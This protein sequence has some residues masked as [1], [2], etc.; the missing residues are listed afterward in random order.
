MKT[1]LKCI[2][3]A[4]ALLAFSCTGSEKKQAGKPFEELPAVDT[5]QLWNFIAALPDADF[6]QKLQSPESRKSFRQVYEDLQNGLLGDGEGE[7][8][9]YHDDFYESENDFYWTDYFTLPDD[10][11]WSNE[12]EDT[13][14]PYVSFHAYMN[15]NGTRMYGVL[16]TGAYGLEKDEKNP[17]KYYWYDIASGKITP[18]ELLVDKPVDDDVL[19]EDSLLLYGADNLYYSLKNKQYEPSF[20]DRGFEMFIES[21]GDPGIRYVWDGTQFNKV[22]RKRIVTLFG[23]GF[24]NIRIGENMPFDVPGYKTVKVKDNENEFVYELRK[25]GETEPTLVFHN[26]R[27][28]DVVDIEI[29]TDRYANMYGIYPGMPYN[30]FMDVLNEI[31]SYYEEPPYVSI[32]TD[33]DE[34]FA[35]I[36]CGFD[37]DF[38]YL[39]DK[40]F[41]KG[42]KIAPNAKIARV[43]AT[44]AVG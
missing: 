20:Y 5:D 23:Y 2:L 39:V 13:M 40:K 17:L 24:S 33:M 12:P 35:Y 22:D 38:Y 37:E 42:D 14:H 8:E 4:L 43:G 19:G 6:P 9:F 18:T 26:T 29:C 41:V 31:N 30:E 27:Y 32:V 16:S 34:D 21:V 25:E 11:D 44:G 1:F 15:P 3:P 7:G 28:M 36:F 10:Y